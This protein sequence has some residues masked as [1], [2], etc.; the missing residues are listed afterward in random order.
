LDPHNSNDIHNQME[1]YMNK[2]TMATMLLLTITIALKAHE[3]EGA[4]LNRSNG[5]S[6]NQ[7]T[8]TSPVANATPGSSTSP[9]SNPSPVASTSSVERVSPTFRRLLTPVNHPELNEAAPVFPQN[10]TQMN[11][12]P[13]FFSIAAVVGNARRNEGL[14][15]NS[16]ASSILGS[17]FSTMSNMSDGS[18]LSIDDDFD[19]NE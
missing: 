14:Q 10:Q 6:P 18:L 8:N 7:E 16:P 12:L 15:Q 2:R 13:R 1:V 9:V 5:N 19:L 4:R 3:D 11:G 17:P